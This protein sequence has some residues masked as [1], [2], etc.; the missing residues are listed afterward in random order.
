MKTALGNCLTSRIRDLELLTAVRGRWERR[1][2][3]LVRDVTDWFE[4]KE[5]LR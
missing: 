4:L 1:A 5:R 2:F 3:M